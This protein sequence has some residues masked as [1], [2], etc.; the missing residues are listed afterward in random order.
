[1]VID[2]VRP[3]MYYTPLEYL[4]INKSYR[5]MS[6]LKAPVGG[7]FSLQFLLIN[8]IMDLDID[9]K[10]YPYLISLAAVKQLPEYYQ[11]SLRYVCFKCSQQQFNEFMN[12]AINF[13]DDRHIMRMVY[14]GLNEYQYTKESFEMLYH[15]LLN[16]KQENKQVAAFREALAAWLEEEQAELNMKESFMSLFSLLLPQLETKAGGFNP[17]ILQHV[18]NNEP[19]KTAKTLLTQLGE[20]SLSLLDMERSYLPDGKVV[21]SSSA[22][23]PYVYPDTSPHAARFTGSNKSAWQIT[24]DAENESNVI[25]LQSGVKLQKRRTLTKD[26]L[27]FDKQQLRAVTR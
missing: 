9:N 22:A 5:H 4:V 12:A 17:T 15:W 16:Y 13:V 27:K 19:A 6:G 21:I 25:Y 3:A 14:L 23:E 1:M 7:K 26:I 8:A 11:V 20:T 2:E 24:I 18:I 10:L